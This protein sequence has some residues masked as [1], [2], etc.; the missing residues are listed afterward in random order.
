MN[1]LV[2]KKIA[3]KIK[4]KYSLD[5]LLKPMLMPMFI[6]KNTGLI[7]YNVINEESFISL[8]PLTPFNI[9]TLLIRNTITRT[10]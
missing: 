3:M 8:V 1:K 7:P 2:M 5:I 9:F 4:N 6:P 10:F